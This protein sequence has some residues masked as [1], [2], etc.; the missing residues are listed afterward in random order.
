M[1]NGISI[2]AIREITKMVLYGTSWDGRDI[3]MEYDLRRGQSKSLEIENIADCQIVSFS[4]EFNAMSITVAKEE[5]S[6][7]ESSD[8]LDYF[9]N[10]FKVQETTSTNSQE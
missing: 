10:N 9:L 1:D 5:Y 3:K 7:L 2:R 8:E 4:S 6:K